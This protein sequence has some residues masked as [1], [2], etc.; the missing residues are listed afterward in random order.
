VTGVIS[1]TK[2]WQRHEQRVLDVLVRALQ[3]LRDRRPYPT[4][5]W[6]L[7]RELHFCLL[8]ANSELWLTRRGG[9][10]YPPNPEA[11]NA[12]DPSDARRAS[13]EHK[14]PDFQ[15]SYIDHAASDPRAG[16]RYYCIECK[17]LGSSGR[18]DWVL[19]SNY[20]EHGIARFIEIEH[21]YGKSV[22]SG[23]MVGYIQNTT[24][25]SIH[26]EVN[27]AAKARGLPAI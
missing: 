10:A 25:T 9:F 27:A 3:L 5:E 20:V 15:W 24:F 17:R 13:R 14:I 23:A 8:E 16:A 6:D 1:G 2:L 7:N 19:N 26:S 4:S 12:P 21:G 18:G 11:K 22:S